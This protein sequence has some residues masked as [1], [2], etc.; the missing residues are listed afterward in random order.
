MACICVSIQIE[1]SYFEFGVKEVASKAEL[2]FETDPEQ[3]N[4]FLEELADMI[5]SV[6]D[7]ATLMSRTE[8]V[9]SSDLEEDGNDDEPKKQLPKLPGSDAESVPITPSGS[10]S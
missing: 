3:F 9:D 10:S 5:H 1:S 4:F 7:R 2:Y 6:G 8:R